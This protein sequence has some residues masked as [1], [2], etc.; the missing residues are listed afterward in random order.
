MDSKTNSA[1]PLPRAYHK[2]DVVES[3]VILVDF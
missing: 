3:F 1:L 2:Y